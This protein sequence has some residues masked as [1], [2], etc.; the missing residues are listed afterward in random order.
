MY[1]KFPCFTYLI[2]QQI[3]MNGELLKANYGFIEM[4][5]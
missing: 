3:W 4:L 5:L 1:D 2:V